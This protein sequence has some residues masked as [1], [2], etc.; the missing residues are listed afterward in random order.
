MQHPNPPPG[1]HASGTDAT[2][3]GRFITT[4]NVAPHSEEIGAWDKAGHE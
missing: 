4:L 1:T 2:T 3:F